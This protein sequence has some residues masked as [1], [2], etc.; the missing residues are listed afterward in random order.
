MF[1]PMLSLTQNWRVWGEEKKVKDFS[2]QQIKR[3]IA[4]RY[5][6]KLNPVL[7]P[8]NQARARG[9][10]KESQT[11]SPFCVK[12]EGGSSKAACLLPGLAFPERSQTQEFK[13]EQ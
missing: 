9:S 5:G 6:S 4:M 3:E 12:L 11:L 7:L 8:I 2:V 1:M 10:R 13:E